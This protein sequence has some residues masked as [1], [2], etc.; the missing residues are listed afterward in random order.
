M[1]HSKENATRQLSFAEMFNEFEQGGFYNIEEAKIDIAEQIN[2][3]MQK[4]GISKAELSRRLGK[5]RAYVTKILQ[6]GANF[7]IESLV[8]I[9][10]AL[11][12]TLDVR[13]I[14]TER[15][16]HSQDSYKKIVRWSGKHE[17]GQANSAC[18]DEDLL[19]A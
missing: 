2:L 10:D 13:L 9:A 19:A 17:P 1:F 6:G 8:K 3:T 7:T 12:C 16:K 5:S 18:P 4:H 15:K 14:Q 11:D